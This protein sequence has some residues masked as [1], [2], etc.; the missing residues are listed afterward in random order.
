MIGWRVGNELE[1]QQQ[2]RK[3]WDRSLETITSTSW[4][5]QVVCFFLFLSFFPPLTSVVKRRTLKQ[6]NEMNGNRRTHTKK[7]ETEKLCSLVFKLFLMAFRNARSPDHTN[8]W[9]SIVRVWVFFLLLLFL[10][11][12]SC[13]S[14]I[15]KLAWISQHK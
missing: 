15:I 10:H 9:H 7:N 11:A 6:K 2:Q 12:A 13:R 8:Y 3:T 5:L 14:F 4:L 1:V